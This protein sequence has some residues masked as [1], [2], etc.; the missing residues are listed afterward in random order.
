MKYGR[1]RLAVILP[2]QE[3]Q[4]PETE[5]HQE[6]QEVVTARQRLQKE[7]GR[8]HH[9]PFRSPFANIQKQGRERRRHA[10]RGEQLEVFDVRESIAG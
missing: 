10:E 3:P 1:Q 5:K 4:T 6:E 7:R 8:E 2:A 9:D